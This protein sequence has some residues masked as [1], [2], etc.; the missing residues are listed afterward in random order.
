MRK[1]NEICNVHEDAQICPSYE[2][3]TSVSTNENDSLKYVKMAI[4]Y[5]Y[6][7]RKIAEKLSDKSNGSLH[8]CLPDVNELLLKLG[9][10]VLSG[11]AWDGIRFVAKKIYDRNLESIKHSN[12]E[13]VILVFT[14][15]KELSN[16]YNYLKEFQ[17]GF[18][19]I[20]DAEYEYIE[21]EMMADFCAEM[22]TEIVMR[23]KR[24]ITIEERIQ[25]YKVARLKI[26]SLVKR[27]IL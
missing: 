1:I 2:I 11:I 12:D 7:Y 3:E 21:E 17:D 26:Q 23:E 4:R 9:E 27:K 8:F 19:N 14:D 5:G 22:E 20:D 15:E 10:F 13:N 25:I 16:F 24:P 6:S 18:S